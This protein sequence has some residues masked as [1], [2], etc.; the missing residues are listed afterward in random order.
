MNSFLSQYVAVALVRHLDEQARVDRGQHHAAYGR[1][2]RD[3]K[4]L[5]SR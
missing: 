2:R 4:R 1:S 5:A 3:R